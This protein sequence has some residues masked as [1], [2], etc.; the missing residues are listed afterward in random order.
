MRT[1]CSLAILVGL[2]TGANSQEFSIGTITIEH[3]WIRLPTS[4]AKSA[5]G[6][7]EIRN[8]GGLSNA[9]VRVESNIS[10]SALLH[11]T[12]TAGNGPRMRELEAGVTVGPTSQISLTPGG[13]HVMF[14]RVRRRLAVGD[15]VP[16][17]L[18][19]SNGA[20]IIVTFQVESPDF[21]SLDH[22]TSQP[23]TDR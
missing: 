10:T 18:D 22:P 12:K 4:G 23:R 21:G 5:E 16:A 13:M 19:F 3:P 1:Q 11:E 7:L 14:E 8:D 20:R 17:A 9:L 15:I 6:Y 2:M